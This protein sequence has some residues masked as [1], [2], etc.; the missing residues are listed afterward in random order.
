MIRRLT[1]APLVLFLVAAPPMAQLA[2]ASS[3]M[4]WTHVDYF[5]GVNDNAAKI[6]ARLVLDTANRQLAVT[7]EASPTLVLATVPYDAITSITYSN[8][9]HA[10]W[11]LATGILVPLTVFTG[12][13]GVLALPFYFMKG[14][15]HWL[16]VTFTGVPEIPQ[17]FLYM[18]LDKSNYL[19]ILAA[20]EAQTQVSVERFQ[21]K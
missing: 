1:A 3:V 16:S 17:D 7:D 12:P 14:K 19:E 15:K 10:R 18:R 4:S 2:N 6:D 11:R 20:L 5:V 9:K 8:S 21:E 13:F